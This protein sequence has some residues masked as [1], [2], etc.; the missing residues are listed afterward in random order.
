MSQR[1]TSF[2]VLPLIVLGA[3][4]ALSFAPAPL[5]GA[6]LPYVQLL[7]FSAFIFYMLKAPTTRSAL[8]GAWLF[9]FSQFSIGLYWFYISM[10]D[11]G[12]LAAPLAGA[13][14]LLFAAFMALYYVL[15]VGLSRFFIRRSQGIHWQEQ[16]LAAI[17]WASA[18]TLFEWIRGTFLTGFP[19]LNIAYAHVDG[20]FAGW[21][22]VLGTYGLSWIVAFAAATLAL[23]ALNTSKTAPKTHN[24]PIAF[25]VLSAVIGIVLGG[26][27]WS[28]PHGSPFFVRLAQGNVDQSIKFDSDL[29]VQGTE[30]YQQLAALPA[31]TPESSPSLIVLPETVI[32]L[33][34]HQWPASFWQQWIDIAAAQ[35]ATLLL[36]APL[37]AQQGSTAVYTN[38][39][40]TI[41]AQSTPTAIQQLQL[42]QRYDKHHLVPFGEFVPMGFRWFVDALAIPLGDFNR[43]PTRQ[44]N[45][46]VGAQY[47]GP[48]ICYEDLFGEEIIQGV[49]DHDTLGPGATV[50]VNMSNLGWFGDSWALRQHLQIAR[51]RSIE[52]ARPMLRATNTGITAAILPTGQVQAAL[53]AHSVGVLDVEVQG[54]TGQTP[55]TLLGNAPVIIGAFILLLL[56][57]RLRLSNQRSNS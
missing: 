25:A 7:A 21:A 24:F 26:I 12:G 14:V 9:G 41:T 56:G 38:S 1:S 29:L 11:Y 28:S 44:A 22:S 6:L 10:H 39:A 17:V 53:P 2:R 33:F 23:F 5:P 57:F 52:T 13:A 30:L 15:A 54:M 47:I 36:G 3:V 19:W 31:K 37:Y 34:Q 45:F 35:N 48:N 46:A 49:R 20:M 8:W 42:E 4:Q 32:P 50:L 51:L 40:F 43:G 27:Q 55:Y 18:W 16:L